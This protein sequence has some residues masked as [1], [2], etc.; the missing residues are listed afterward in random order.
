MVSMTDQRPRIGGESRDLA[1]TVK[2]VIC[3]TGF[4]AAVSFIAID[5]HSYSFGENVFY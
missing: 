5:L 2:P 3:T 4:D 1:I